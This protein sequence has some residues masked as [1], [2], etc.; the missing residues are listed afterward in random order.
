MLLIKQTFGKIKIMQKLKIK[1]EDGVELAAVLF[2]PVQPKAA[3]QLCIGTGAKKEFYFPFIKFLVENHYAV[4][5]FEYRG[6]CE[7]APASMKDC[8]YNYIEYGTQDMPAV[9]E[10]LD[11]KYPHL[12]KLLVGHSVGGMNF[13][14]M[15]NYQKLSGVVAVAQVRVTGK[16]CLLGIE[17]RHYF[18]SIFFVRL[19][20]G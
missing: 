15:P 2:E 20:Y 16:I 19:A 12:P 11:R 8:D 1:C 18:S 6:T 9:L 3:V 13:G 10:F 17:C 5:T 14:L 7:S 4:C